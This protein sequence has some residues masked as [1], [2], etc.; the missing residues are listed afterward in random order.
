MIWTREEYLSH[1]T[2]KGTKREMFTQL[3]GPLIGLNQQ[4]RAQGA[5]EDE[6]SLKAFGWD[7]VKYAWVPFHTGA[8]SG[9]KERI[10]EENDRER[11][12]ID[13]LGRKM[14]LSKQCATL[15]LPFSYPVQTP[16]DFEK[17]RGW[18]DF[19]ESRI[20]LEALKT[21][22]KQRAEGTLIMLDMPGGFD[23]PRNLMGEENLCY[24][25]Y[26]EPEMIEDM[27]NTCAS[28]MRR[29][30]EII[31][32]ETEID[33][34]HVHEDMAGISGPL[35]GP[36]QVKKFI[37]P[38]YKSIW[39][40]AKKGGAQ[41]FS[42]DSDGNMNGVI[43]AFLDAGVNCMYPAEPK[44]GMDIVALRKKYG[45]RL[46][47]KGGIDK[48]ALRGTR[49]DIDRELDYK[50]SAPMLGG[51]TVFA[52]DHLIPDGVPIE[53]YRYYVQEGRKRLGLPPSPPADY[54]RMAF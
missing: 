50:M 44:A 25:Y 21:L 31:L 1:M 47:F 16:E 4:W 26:D 42:Q 11:I 12:S 34:L 29:G 40:A 49:Q 24:A 30:L 20:D 9:I 32:N 43:D 19:D 10:L 2:F 35:A 33:L 6:I 5:S 14:R 3:F 18:F 39:E 54:V 22:K 46:A 17:I 41:L 52:L 27:L 8:R 37:A 7:S 38:Y 48:F 53:N 23:F 51:G 28:M 36:S 45:S 13:S 15:A